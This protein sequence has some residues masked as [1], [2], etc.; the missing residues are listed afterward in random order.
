MLWTEL[1]LGLSEFDVD[2]FDVLCFPQELPD[3]DMT[4]T[5]FYSLYYVFWRRFD[6]REFLQVLKTFKKLP[7]GCF[8]FKK[9]TLPGN[10]DDTWRALGGFNNRGPHDP[11]PNASNSQIFN[12][13]TIRN[14]QDLDLIIKMVNSGSD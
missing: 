1:L 8:Y 3:F 7:E 12:K 6:L 2:L 11:N 14:F 4:S 5:N 13:H 9:Q 10:R